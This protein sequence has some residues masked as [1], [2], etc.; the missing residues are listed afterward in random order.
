MIVALQVSLDLVRICKDNIV[1]GA[2][3]ATPTYNFHTE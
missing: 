3:H 2:Q 1:V